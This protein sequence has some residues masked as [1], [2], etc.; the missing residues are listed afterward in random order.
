M[1]RDE[2]RKRHLPRGR[3]APDH[4]NCAPGK[5]VNKDAGFCLLGHSF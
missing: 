2:T 1:S 5:S 3:T 4:E